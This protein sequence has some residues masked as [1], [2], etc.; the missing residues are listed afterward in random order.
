[1][2]Q[3]RTS[4]GWFT[5]TANWTAAKA[6]IIQA[7]L[8]LVNFGRPHFS[9]ALRPFLND[10]HKVEHLIRPL[11]FSR[12]MKK[13]KRRSLAAES[14]TAFGNRITHWSNCDVNPELNVKGCGACGL[15]PSLN[16]PHEIEIEVSCC[17]KLQVQATS[18]NGIKRENLPLIRP[19]L[20]TY[21]SRRKQLRWP[22]RRL[23]NCFILQEHE[24]S[25]IIRV[26]KQWEPNEPDC[27][28]ENAEA[29]KYLLFGLQRGVAVALTSYTQYDLVVE[30]LL[31]G[32]K[33]ASSIENSHQ[34]LGKF[35][36]CQGES[37]HLEASGDP[38]R[39]S[40]RS[41]E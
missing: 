9:E 5:R 14:L 12:D 37:E 31:E 24:R 41:E 13:Y 27:E 2:K 21:L 4:N 20:E 33:E 11:T 16:D 34:L 26:W 17:E 28:W 18:T 39:D 10:F 38:V 15:N 3:Y 40:R 22:Q 7:I 23:R 19:C 29:A 30:E 1:V 25:S 36:S 6:S 32:C 35:L 8:Y